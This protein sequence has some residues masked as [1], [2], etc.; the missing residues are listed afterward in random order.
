MADQDQQGQQPATAQAPNSSVAARLTFESTSEFVAYSRGQRHKINSVFHVQAPEYQGEEA[1]RGAVDIVAVIDVSGSMSGSKLDLAK[2]TLEFLIKNLSQTDHMGLVVY[3]SDV[4]VA[5]PLTRMDAEGKRTATAAL[6]TLRAQRCT[7]LSGGLFKGIEMMQGRERSAASVSSVLL[8]TDGIANEGV[9]G[10]NLITATRQ[11]MGDN[12][13]YSLYTFGYGSNH[14]EELLKDLSEVGNGMYYYI[15]NNDTIPESFGDCLGG[16]L[17][18][19]GQ[20]VKVTITTQ[21]GAKITTLHTQRQHTVSSDRTR[22]E[23]QLGDIQAEE[24]RDLLVELDIPPL[25]LPQPDKNDRTTT[26]TT[27]TAAAVHNNDDDEDEDDE[28]DG[29]DV[30]PA[31]EKDA[32][33]EEEQQEE[34]DTETAAKCD[35]DVKKPRPE[36]VGVPHVTYAAA[37]LE[38]VNVISA[39]FEKETASLTLTRPAQA[40]PKAQ[41]DKNVRRQVR[42]VEAANAMREALQAARRGD[43]ASAQANLTT[44]SAAM[45]TEAAADDYIQQLLTDMDECQGNFSTPAA[46][47]GAGRYKATAMM[48]M[49]CNQRASAPST[50]TTASRGVMRKKAKDSS[51][52]S[53]FFKKK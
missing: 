7:N 12:P 3:H 47:N 32:E 41:P 8:M 18:V 35:D 2:A 20:N 48:Q 40:P 50:Y 39:A 14:E 38:Y 25:E 37:V 19:V 10:P 1:A 17:S 13:S 34:K 53:S 51:V 4:S 46:Y 49:H 11:L 5:F 30:K 23:I 52:F 24:Q 9:R 43:F 16:L 26:T 44:T 28:G 33:K 36:D 42:R 27:T 6:S 45:R 21:N 15:E 22:A 31:S 29:D